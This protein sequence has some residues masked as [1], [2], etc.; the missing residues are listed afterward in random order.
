MREAHFAAVFIIV[1]PGVV[2][3]GTARWPKRIWVYMTGFNRGFR[4]ST[5]YQHTFC[6]IFSEVKNTKG[7]LCPEFNCSQDIGEYGAMS[8]QAKEC[9]EYKVIQ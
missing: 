8:Q 1:L 9:C 5:G 2:K 4:V 7:E 6:Q 3:R